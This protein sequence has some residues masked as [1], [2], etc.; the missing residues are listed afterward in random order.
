M[1]SVHPEREQAFLL[2]MIALESLVLAES[3][4]GELGYRLR[5]RVSHLLGRNRGARE[6]V[7]STVK[8]LYDIRSKIVHRGSHEV[9]D[10]NLGEIRSITKNAILRLLL[11]RTICRYR[12]KKDLAR[13][14]ENLVLR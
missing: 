1:A 3:D 14:F 5:V 10:G 2:F 7:S 8:N 13:W 11:H 12:K 9:T 6:R 4:T